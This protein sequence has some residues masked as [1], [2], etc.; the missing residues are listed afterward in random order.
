MNFAMRVMLLGGMLLSGAYAA[1]Q[2]IASGIVSPQQGKVQD[3]VATT[4]RQGTASGKT[5][6]MAHK[7]TK[8]PVAAEKPEVPKQDSMIVNPV[9][10][11][12]QSVQ[13]RGVRG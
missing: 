6:R 2:D 5:A 8:K 7:K 1:E 10:S 4:V 3:K 11:T 13:L 12:E 9:D